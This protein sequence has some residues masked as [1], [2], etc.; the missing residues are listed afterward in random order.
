MKEEDCVAELM[1]MYESLIEKEKE[2][3]S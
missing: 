2:Q 1:K 3:Q